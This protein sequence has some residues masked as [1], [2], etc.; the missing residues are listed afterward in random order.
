M[1]MESLSSTFQVAEIELFYRTKVKA[2][3]HVTIKSSRD[4]YKVLI[5]S[6]DQNKIEFLEQSKDLLLNMTN[7]VFRNLCIIKR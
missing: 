6:W 7:R 4:A 5:Q 3:V 1:I 2:S